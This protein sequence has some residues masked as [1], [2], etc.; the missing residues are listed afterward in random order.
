[1]IGRAGH[2]VY[3]VTMSVTSSTRLDHQAV[4]PSAPQGVCRFAALPV[5]VGH[6]GSRIQ[7]IRDLDHIRGF[8]SGTGPT[9]FFDL[10]LAAVFLIIIYL[11]HPLLGLLATAG[12]V[13]GGYPD[14]GGREPWPC[15][16]EGR[17]GFHDNAYRL[18]R[19]GEPQCRDEET[20]SRIIRR[21]VGR[22]ATLKNRVRRLD[23]VR[24]RTNSTNCKTED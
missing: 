6:E 17:D 20:V 9:A 22:S 3:V 8:V 12:A 7:P 5:R 11:L 13:I 1:M 15:L 4:I 24:Q 14:A 23:A 2:D 18:C 21:Y 10:P 16:R 19:G